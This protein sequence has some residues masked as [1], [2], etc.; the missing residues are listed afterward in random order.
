M[1]GKSHPYGRREE[2]LAL[3]LVLLL[4]PG[5]KKGEEERDADD[6]EDADQRRRVLRRLP[7]NLD[8]RGT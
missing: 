6:D 8:I 5:R 4:A 3:H 7:F 1:V 2:K